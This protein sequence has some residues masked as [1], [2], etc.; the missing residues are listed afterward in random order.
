MEEGRSGMEK[1]CVRRV[2]YSSSFM[3]EVRIRDSRPVVFDQILVSRLLLPPLPSCLDSQ[4]TSPVALQTATRPPADVGN[5]MLIGNERQ[6]NLTYPQK[7]L[8]AEK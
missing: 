4:D 5:G 1:G 2:A 6:L 8:Q 3:S 7:R